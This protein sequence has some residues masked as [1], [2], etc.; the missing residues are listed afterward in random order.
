MSVPIAPI[1]PDHEA[2]ELVEPSKHVALWQIRRSRF[3]E[4]GRRDDLIT[5]LVA[6]C[7]AATTVWVSGYSVGWLTVVF[8]IGA[9]ISVRIFLCNRHSMVCSLD[10]SDSA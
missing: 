1:D 2:C 9:G 10:F 3:C 7:P 8:D 5:G 4:L 6:P